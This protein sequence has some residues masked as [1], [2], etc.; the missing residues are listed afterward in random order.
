[1]RLIFQSVTEKSES[2]SNHCLCIILHPYAAGQAN[3]V[4][5]TQEV[6]LSS[7]KKE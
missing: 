1:M 5:N 2:Q 6:F 7:W 4:E 3:E